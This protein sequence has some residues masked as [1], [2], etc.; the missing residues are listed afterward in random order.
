M[1]NT[2]RS[3]KPFR[4]LGGFRWKPVG[5]R[6]TNRKADFFEKEGEF[7]TAGFFVF[8]ISLV[9]RTFLSTREILFSKETSRGR[10]L[11]MEFAYLLI[12][13]T[14]DVEICRTIRGE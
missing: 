12:C 1:V 2:F 14:A 10:T 6:S 3:K 4:A 7:S 11:G 13:R 8:R 5:E 9:I